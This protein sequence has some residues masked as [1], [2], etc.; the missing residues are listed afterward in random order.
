M[1]DWVTSSL[2]EKCGIY[3]I[4]VNTVNLCAKQTI[5]M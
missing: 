5:T 4:D 1:I 3:D 2:T